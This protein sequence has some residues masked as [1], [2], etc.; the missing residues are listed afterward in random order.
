MPDKRAVA[1]WSRKMPTFDD[2][3]E[4]IAARFDLGPKARALVQEVLGLIAAQPGALGG[5][6]NKFLAAG[7]DIKVASWLRG[8]YPMALSVRQVKKALGAEAVKAI[9][10]K[11]GVTEGFGAKV[12]GYAIPKI[13]IWLRGGG[14]VPE[15]ISAAIQ[16]FPRPT[17][18]S[19][20]PSPAKFSSRTDGRVPRP[21]IQG[22]EDIPARRLVFPGAALVMTL[23]LFG[24]AIIAGTP[25]DQ[26]PVQS[27]ARVAQN[28][29]AASPVTHSTQSAQPSGTE[30]ARA[31]VLA[32]ATPGKAQAT[33][34]IQTAL[35]ALA[36]EFPVIVQ[37]FHRAAS[38]SFGRLRT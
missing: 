30:A 5:F 1:G 4:E 23:G 9:A 34:S 36:I 11:V 7:L 13:I 22:G 2:L 14:T 38:L 12:L 35:E 17:P 33:A 21:R 26:A 15:A 37:R 31:A 20:P 6:L 19:S 28:A 16:A 8:P 3:T 25:G 18:A 10:Q 24:Y 32:S 27:P 29:P